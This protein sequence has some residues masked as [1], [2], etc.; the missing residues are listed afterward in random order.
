MNDHTYHG[1][2]LD[3]QP[4]G[5]PA[6]SLYRDHT[7]HPKSPQWGDLRVIHRSW[8]PGETGLYGRHRD[9]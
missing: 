5:I 3:D 4:V 2:P 7:A 6:R 8:R 1:G 9:A